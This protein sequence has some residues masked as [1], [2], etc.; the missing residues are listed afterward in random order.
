MWSMAT[1]NIVPLLY[2]FAAGFLRVDY[3]FWANQ[4][5]YFTDDVLPCLTGK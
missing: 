1:K 4:K 3:I 5:P 2:A